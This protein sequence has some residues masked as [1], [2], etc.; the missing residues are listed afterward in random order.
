M[1]ASWMPHGLDWASLHIRASIDYC[2]TV[3]GPCLNQLQISK[4]DSLLY[5]AGK[6]CTGALKFTSRDNVLK[7][8]GW[9]STSKRL[10]FSSLCQFHKVMHLNTTELVRECLPPLNA[11]RYPTKRTFQ[12]YPCKK[13]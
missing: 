4:L 8:L 11:S 2:L 10:E 1:L 13:N 7:E 3:F 5:R 12:N 6:I 9:E